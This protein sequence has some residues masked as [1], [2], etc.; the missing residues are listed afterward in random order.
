MWAHYSEKFLSPLHSVHV[1]AAFELDLQRYKKIVVTSWK[2]LPI[3]RQTV[4][5]KEEKRRSQKNM[6]RQEKKKAKGNEGKYNVNIVTST[7]R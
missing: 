1:K 6:S 4:E 3:N 7:I 2:N 5:N